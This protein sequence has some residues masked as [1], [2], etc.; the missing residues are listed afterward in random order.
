MRVETWVR[1]IFRWNVLLPVTAL[2]A[3]AAAA[4][5]AGH[6]VKARADEAERQLR[7]R[8]QARA[9]VVAS[10]DVK[11]GQQLEGSALAVR[12]MP[13]DF[14]PADAVNPARAGELLG[15]R[16]AIDIRRGTPVVPAA[17]LATRTEEPLAAQLVEGRRA[18]TIQVDE[19]N[20]LSGQ[21]RPG[22]TVDLLYSRSESAASKLVPLLERVQVLATGTST[23]SQDQSV[24]VPGERDFNTVTLLVTSDE[25][26]RIVLAEQAGRI[27][28]LL[29]SAA[30]VQPVDIG[31]RDSRDLMRGAGAASA[32]TGSDPR[33]ELLTGGHGAEP[34]RSWLT[35]GKPLASIDGSGK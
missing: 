17:L 31:T 25:A 33:I 23:S 29:R 27:T 7:E 34:A 6:Y 30:D 12:E 22:D 5:G 10:R 16:A 3:G 11:R 19:V 13:R 32:R 14:V 20:S 18:L 35:I 8:Y 26:A 28:V 15:G 9:V 4:A 1:T 21:L 2:V 24:D